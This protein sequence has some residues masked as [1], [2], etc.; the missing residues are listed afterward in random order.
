VLT[1]GSSGVMGVQ[2]SH[3][4]GSQSSAY[5]SGGGERST[6][7]FCSVALPDRRPFASRDV[8]VAERLFIVAHPDTFDNDILED[9]FCRFGNMIG[10]YFMPGCYLSS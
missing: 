7:N 8:P 9:V 10:A 6:R 4:Y 5:G 1:A 2:G 3:N